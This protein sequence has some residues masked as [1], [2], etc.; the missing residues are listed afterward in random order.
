M[1]YQL[2]EDLTEQDALVLLTDLDKRFGWSS[3]ALT[4]DSVEHI[5]SHKLTDEE[6][7]ELRYS[8]EWHP[9]L[10]NLIY[11]GAVA[12]VIDAVLKVLPDF[13]TK[14]T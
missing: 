13:H 6:W 2:S 7:D 1:S 3:L 5:F 4:R 9:N 11:D 14:E 12:L 10:G 8:D